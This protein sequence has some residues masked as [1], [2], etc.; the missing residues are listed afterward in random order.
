MLRLNYDNTLTPTLLLHVGVGYQQNN[1]FDNAPVLNYNAQASLGLTGATLN[2]NF[3]LFNNLCGLGVQ[4]TH[5]SVRAVRMTSGL[6]DKRTATG[7][8]QGGTPA[9]TWVKGSHT[10]KAGTDIYFSVVPQIPLHQHRRR[11]FFQPQRNHP[12]ST[13]VGAEFLRRNGRT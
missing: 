9:P 10:L 5:A 4:T 11:V 1:F 12:R 2:R 13:L 3:P 6:P 7:K 8:N